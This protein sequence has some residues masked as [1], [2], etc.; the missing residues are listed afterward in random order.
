[1]DGLLIDSEDLYTLVVNIILREY[2]K[3]DLPWSIKAQLQG[4]PAPQVRVL[5][6]SPLPLSVAN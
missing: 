4:R 5:H 6:T 3:P 2:G 1:M